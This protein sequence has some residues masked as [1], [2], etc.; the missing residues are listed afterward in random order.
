MI[1]DKVTAVMTDRLGVSEQEI[2]PETSLI[3]DLAADSLDLYE[4]MM[5]LEEE[6]NVEIPQELT[7]DIE[8][9]EH[10]VRVLKELGVED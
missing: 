4:L 3:E 1:Y 2:T 7:N 6:F 8:N 9:V 5:A 10:I